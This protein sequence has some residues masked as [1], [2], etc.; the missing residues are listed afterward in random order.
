MAEL[1]EFISV[2]RWVRDTAYPQIKIW[3]DEVLGLQAQVAIDAS[4]VSTKKGEI[5]ATALVVQ[6]NSDLVAVSLATVTDLEASASSASA[7]ATISANTATTEAS[8]ILALQAT[9]QSLVAGSSAT[10]T[11][12]PTTGIMTIG[13]PR[14]D[15]GEKGDAF[16]VNAVGVFADRS[17]YD[18]QPDGFS[19]MATDLGLLYF[20]LGATAGV[21]SAGVPFGKGDTG[22]AGES[23][24]MRV[25]P[26]GNII[27]WQYPS[28]GAVWHDLISL[29]AIYTS[30]FVNVTGDTLT[31]QLKGITPVSA[32]DLTR[33]DYVD[34][35]LALKAP[36]ASP[37]LTGTPT[38]PT[39]TAGDNSTAIATTAY[40]ESSKL[41]DLAV[42]TVGATGDY[43][44]LTVAL[45]D[46][47]VTGTR[48][49][50]KVQLDLLLGH[51]EEP[52]FSYVGT[53]REEFEWIEIMSSVGQALA[54]P[55]TF[56][57][58]ASL[59]RFSSIVSAPIINV[60]VDSQATGASAFFDAVFSFITV[61]KV[62]FG[63]NISLV[64][65]YSHG[66]F[67]AGYCEE[68]SINDSIFLNCKA[69]YATGVPLILLANSHLKTNSIYMSHSG[70]VGQVTYG[71]HATYSYI[72]FGNT[73]I[74]N[75]TSTNKFT[76][77]YH[78]TGCNVIAGS[79]D[80]EEKHCI[81]FINAVST[82]L[83]AR[84]LWNAGTST[85]DV[86]MDSHSQVNIGITDGVTSSNV[87]KN[88]INASGGL[89]LAP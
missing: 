15:K 14:G 7:S 39:Q 30:Q 62:Q 46:L 51:I 20:R 21:W 71:I 5:D 53:N 56:N 32:S 79:M 66:W 61:K 41:P 33:K 72:A 86:L 4:D 24:N 3:Y 60:G 45:T 87:T 16:V 88:V 23:I 74:G 34:N 85:Y 40:F 70:K 31:G 50:K 68:V 52:D 2:L 13:V 35:G 17:L 55:P 83:T 18:A 6:D 27:Q 28:E 43:A 26:V 36:L 84:A 76:N 42:K 48:V 69:G 57:N 25:E 19:F 1:P 73:G 12:N 75:S 64:N 9:A 77:P 89:L 67:Y 82:Q 8:K 37:A 58:T 80:M 47:M 78:F 22:D 65:L 49:A 54:T 81:N 10:A 38:A 44:N 63:N 59:Y 29:D 11:Y